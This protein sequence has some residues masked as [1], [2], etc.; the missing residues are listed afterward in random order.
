MSNINPHSAANDDV[1]VPAYSISRILSLKTRLNRACAEF[2]GK[3]LGRGTFD[4]FIATLRVTLPRR[5]QDVAEDVLMSSLQ[6]IAGTF[7]TRSKLSEVT[8]RVAGNLQQLRN[9]VPVPAWGQQLVVEWAPVQVL[10]SLPAWSRRRK[11]GADF[12]LRFLAGSPCPLRVQQC[13]T[14]AFCGLFSRELGFTAPWNDFPFED[15]RQLVNLRFYVKIEPELCGSAPG[16]HEVK[17]PPGCRTWNRNMFR[18][19]ARRDPEIF[20]C[21]AEFPLDV[22]CHACPVGEE[23][24]Q[25]AVHERSFVPKYCPRCQLDEA[26]HDP[27]SSRKI[28]VDCFRVLKR[29]G[30]A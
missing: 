7:L 24:C 28:C 3:K 6:G 11:P 16:F 29:K 8:W 12:V 20:S 2:A 23:H 21:P 27:A 15:T 22:P 18:L 13:W 1:P 9:C 17:A 30:E 4:D 5:G 14:K 19:R 10:S 26:W 25:A